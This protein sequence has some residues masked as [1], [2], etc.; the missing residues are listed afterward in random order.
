MTVRID[1]A[2]TKRFIDSAF[3]LPIAHE[4]APYSPIAQTAYAE[5]RVLQNDVTPANLKHSNESDGVLRVILRYPAG[6]GA[7]AAKTMGDNIFSE[8][9]IGQRI[10]Y[11]GATVII[12]SQQRQPGVQEDGWFV[13]V[14]SMAYRA[15]LSRVQPS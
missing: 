7:V 11:S 1:Q 6:K 10:T 2:L 14:L 5:L 4:N 9:T 3:G 8:F 15:Y 13:I 12:T